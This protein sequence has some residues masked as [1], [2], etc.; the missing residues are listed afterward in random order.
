MVLKEVLL[1][2]ERLEGV[3]GM[4]TGDHMV[5]LFPELEGRRP[6]DRERMASLLR[7]FLE[8]GSE[9]QRLYIVGR[10][11]G[12]FQTLRDMES[13]RLAAEAERFCR[14]LGVSEETFGGIIEEIGGRYN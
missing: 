2:L 12:I 9:R 7:A 1:F 10:R 3:T 14:E 6:R 8:M 11:L 5:N 4:L 13:P